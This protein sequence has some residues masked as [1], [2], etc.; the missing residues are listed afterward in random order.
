MKCK[1]QIESIK[2]FVLSNEIINEEKTTITFVSKTISTRSIHGGLADRDDEFVIYLSRE[3]WQVKTYTNEFGQR[4][5]M[6]QF[7][8]V[9]NVN[10]R[11]ISED[12]IENYFNGEESNLYDVIGFYKKVEEILKENN[13]R[14]L[15]NRP[16]TFWYE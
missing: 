12:W 11:G 5:N 3:G 1:K 8:D 4:A 10:I 15:R 2:E 14:S 6:S 16:R 9:F 13:D 7:N